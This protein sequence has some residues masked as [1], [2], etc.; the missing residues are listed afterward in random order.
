MEEGTF[1]DFA[2]VAFREDEQWRVEAL[3]ERAAADLDSLVAAV[4]QQ[5][6][7]G[8]ALGFC[9]YDDDFFLVVRPRGDDVRL[10]VSD[11]SAGATWPLARKA[12][13]AIGAADLSEP[14]DDDAEQILPA[15]DLGIFA[16]LGVS[17][18]MLSTICADL[19]LFPDEVLAQIATHIGFGTQFDQAVEAQRV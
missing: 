4:R 19:D 17:S 10:L 3:P 6:S 14:T 2:L 7:E 12:L 1:L 16:D 9:S 11:S 13:E 15:G 8:V 18:L 5:P